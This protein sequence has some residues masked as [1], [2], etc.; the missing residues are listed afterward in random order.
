MKASLVAL[1]ELVPDLT[2]LLAEIARV[3]IYFVSFDVRVCAAAF[4]FHWL[5]L[6]VL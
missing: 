2:A 4:T 6:S 3:V 5:S 1:L